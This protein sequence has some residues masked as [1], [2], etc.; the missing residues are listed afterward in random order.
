MKIYQKIYWLKKGNLFELVDILKKKKY[1]RKR[2]EL[3]DLFQSPLFDI[4]VHWNREK[5]YHLAY[6]LYRLFN[7][8]Y[9]RITG[10]RGYFCYAEWVFC[11]MEEKPFKKNSLK[12]ISSKITI[13]KDKYSHV[14]KEVDDMS[15]FFFIFF[16]IQNFYEIYSDICIL[17][18]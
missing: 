2:K 17:T 14:S 16:N 6:L 12:K 7:E 11:D 15:K 13:E 4:K 3:F 18:F 8:D 5:K 10:N 1:I 9:I